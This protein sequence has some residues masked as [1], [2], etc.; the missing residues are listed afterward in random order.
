MHICWGQHSVQCSVVILLFVLLQLLVW[1]LFIFNFH[2]GDSVENN[3]EIKQIPISYPIDDIWGSNGMVDFAITPSK[4]REL[5][6]WY[7]G[8]LPVF[9]DAKERQ[10]LC[11]KFNLNSLPPSDNTPRLYFGAIFNKEIDVFQM[12]LYEMID[13]L[14]SY[15]I[16]EA[17]ATFTGVPRPMNFPSL[18][19]QLQH[20]TSPSGRPLLEKVIYLP[21]AQEGDRSYNGMVF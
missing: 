16:V 6:N 20:H 14:H 1:F 4:I 9:S 21:W 7:E 5:D 12:A 15:T 19:K 11:S 2:Y 8:N 3:V 10:K 17:N 18:F 13:V